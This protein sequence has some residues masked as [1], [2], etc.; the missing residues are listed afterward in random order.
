M[1]KRKSK[2]TKN[3]VSEARNKISIQRSELNLGFTE[4]V[5]GV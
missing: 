1:F 3:Y 5:L 2:A 4:A